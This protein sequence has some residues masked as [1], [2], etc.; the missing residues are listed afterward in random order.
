[1]ST[2]PWYSTWFDSDYYYRL[3]D[4]RNEGEAAAFVD[5]LLSRLPFDPGDRVIDLACGR[6]RHSRFLAERGLK[7]IGLDLSSGSIQE[8]RLST[9]PNQ[10]FFQHDMLQPFPTN[11]VVAVFNFFTSFGYFENDQKNI[12]VLHNVVTA[13]KPGGYFVLDFLNVEKATQT[14]RDPVSLERDGI[15]FLLSWEQTSTHLIKQIQVKDGLTRQTFEERLQLL[16]LSDFERFFG[17]VG[18]EIG[19]VY[20]DY[21]L[22][23][24]DPQTSERL[25]LIA[26]KPA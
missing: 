19:A 25:I 24:F 15:N 18:L 4:Y 8:A 20:G 6:G 13:L 3:Y 10:E 12:Q 16:R 21:S 14:L 9:H 26:H 17:V 1:M 11:D 2:T 22:R 7:V 23:V 5:A